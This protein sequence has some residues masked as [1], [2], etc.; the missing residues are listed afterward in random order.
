MN[1][2][3]KPNTTKSKFNTMSQNSNHKNLQS[4]GFP[5]NDLKKAE[6]PYIKTPGTIIDEYFRD[7]H[8]RQLVGPQ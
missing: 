4:Q 3:M 8:L 2:L 7:K 5:S 1:L 6:A